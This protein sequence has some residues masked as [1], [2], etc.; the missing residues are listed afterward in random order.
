MKKAIFL[1]STILVLVLLISFQTKEKSIKN[2]YA[3]IVAVADYQY[4]NDL[5]FTV[6][7]AQLFA[8]FLMSDE[9]GDIPSENIYLLTDKMAKKANIIHYGKKMFARASSEDRVIFYFTGHGT[10]GAFL[11]YDTDINGAEKVLYFS[12]I[13][14]IFKTAECKTKLLFADACFSGSFKKKQ[15]DKIK[16]GINEKENDEIEVA[17]M[18]SSSGDETSLEMGKLRQGVFSYYL[19]HG[20][21]GNA[22]KDNNKLV[23]IEELHNYVSTNVKA[24]AKELN[25]TQTPITFGKFDKNM[26]V[27][28]MD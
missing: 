16:S 22:D 26:V 24:K 13:K 14:E 2:T 27:A 8:K 11:P 25:E 7:D 20:L 1:I 5:N 19:T 18:L 23:T 12:E 3:V 10:K 6:N 21:K 4:I 9:G 17:L 28:E 15:I